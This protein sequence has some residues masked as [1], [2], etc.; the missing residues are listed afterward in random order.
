M[1]QLFVDLKTAYGLV[2]R[3]VL[4]NILNEFGISMKLVRLIKMFLNESYSRSR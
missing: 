2:R 3:V 4:Y 1:H